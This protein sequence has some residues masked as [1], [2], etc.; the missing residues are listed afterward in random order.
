[1]M[2]SANVPMFGTSGYGAVGQSV[3]VPDFGR[4]WYEYLGMDTLVTDMALNDVGWRYTLSEQRPAVRRT[5]S[6]SS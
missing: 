4:W 6:C 1:M 2:Q 5:F 3:E